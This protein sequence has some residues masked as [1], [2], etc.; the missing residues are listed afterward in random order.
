VRQ[1]FTAEQAAQSDVGA[2]EPDAIRPEGRLDSLGGAPVLRGVTDEGVES[3]G[4]SA[5]AGRHA[6]LSSRCG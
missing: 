6:E 4:Y 2:I 3:L 1:Q 5:S